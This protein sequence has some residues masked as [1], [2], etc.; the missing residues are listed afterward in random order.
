MGLQDKAK[1]EL[2]IFDKLYQEQHQ[3]QD[4][5]ELPDPE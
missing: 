1:K 4:T 3:H 2:E 5:A